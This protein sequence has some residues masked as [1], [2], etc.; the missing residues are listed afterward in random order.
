[1]RRLLTA[2]VT[3]VVVEISVTLLAGPAFGAASGGEGPGGTVNVGASSG[4]SAGGLPGTPGGG[5]PGGPGSAGGGV[6]SAWS[7]TYSK[8]LLNDEGGIAPGGPTPGSWYSMTCNNSATGASFNQTLWIADQTPN[9]GTPAVDPYV[10]ALQA[11]RSL[12]LPPPSMH[13]N[14]AGT[15]VV[16]LSTWLWIDGSIWHSYSVE[17]SA[18]SVT[19]TAVA[20]PT[21][22]T[23]TM[24]D[25]NVVVCG[26]PGV[27]FDTGRP[28]SGQTTACAHVYQASSAGQP[29]PDGNPNDASFAVVATVSW[30]VQW[31]AQGAPGGG[32]LP[33]LTTS[34]STGLRV[35]QVESIF[36]SASARPRR[37]ATPELT[38]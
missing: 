28:A 27:P 32:S 30:S 15:S 12:Q 3:L 16:N 10:L 20:T 29:A 33:G 6:G 26:G 36:S 2:L 37:S 18:G 35:E 17:A 8:L 22:V 38:L 23:W 31:S 14:P 7:C 11:E 9:P 25:G 24:G 4:G 21:S 19:A 13:F 34:S 5:G 1:M